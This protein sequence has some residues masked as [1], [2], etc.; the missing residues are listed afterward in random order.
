MTPL[1]RRPGS[2]CRLRLLAWLC[3]LLSLLAAGDPDLPVSACVGL[4]FGAEAVPLASV[5]DDE[6]SPAERAEPS[7]S[8]QLTRHKRDKHH[9]EDE[10]A[11]VRQ[12]HLHLHTAG[13]PAASLLPSTPFERGIQRPLR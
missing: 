1:L 2:A 8:Q 9:R 5:E 13:S 6:E 11:A 12:P 3:C 10:T 7:S 4:A